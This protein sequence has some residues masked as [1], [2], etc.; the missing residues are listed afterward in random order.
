MSQPSNLPNQH[1]QLARFGRLLRRHTAEHLRNYL[2]TAVVG[3]GAMMLVMGFI[4]Y[5]NR[6]AIPS[7]AQNAFFVLFLLTGGSILAS[8]AFTQFGD[9]RQATVALLLPAS[10]LEKYLVAWIFSLPLFL[11]FFIPLFSLAN[12]A[13]AY[14]SAAPG[15]TPE[16]L[17]V[18]ED[19]E[20]AMGTFWTLTVLHAAWL[21]G[22]IY[23]E[24]AHFIKTA[25]LV[26]GLFGIL[27]VVN[28]QALKLLITPELRPVPP[29]TKLQFVEKQL[30][31]T[32]DLPAAQFPWLS[33]VPVA[34]ALLLWA[35]AYFR[36]TEKQL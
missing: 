33:L 34:L 11:L 6:D 28:F 35:A 19:G 4:A 22:G 23:F 25:F 12:A 17:N 31:Y 16:L 2:L 18:F 1:F 13:V 24:K 3:T 27:A 14:V 5:L 9:K 21:W 32:L 29:F 20:R 8:T 15:Q 36:L 26:F 30:S 10:H 7:G